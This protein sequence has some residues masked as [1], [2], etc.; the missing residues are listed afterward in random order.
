MSVTAL[1]A[2][3]HVHGHLAWLA[4]L[5]LYHPAILLRRPRRR[6]VGA[7]L[8][9]TILVTAAA[10]L[11]ALLYPAY[12][13]ELKPA[14]FASSPLVGGLFERKEHLGVAAVVLA[15]SGL[16]LHLGEQR[17]GPSDRGAT[18]PAFVAFLGAALF[19]TS[20]ALMGVVVAVY[21]SF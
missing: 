21:R 1:R 7:A 16:G 13:G 19:A 17:E 9:A 5:A 14:I 15:W 10:A 4:T 18:R 11:G 6:A 8:S 12:R 20:A 2:I 3:E